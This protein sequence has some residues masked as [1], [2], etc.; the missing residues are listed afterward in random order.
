MLK[1]R[2]SAAKDSEY[3]KFLRVKA[4]FVFLAVGNPA[5]DNSRKRSAKVPALSPSGD[6][7]QIKAL[8]I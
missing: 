5:T 1:S 3:D 2:N 6:P 8:Q 4:L 7:D